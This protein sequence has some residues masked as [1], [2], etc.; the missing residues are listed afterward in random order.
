MFSLHY[1]RRLAELGVP[2]RKLLACATGSPACG[3][4]VSRMLLVKEKIFTNEKL[5]ISARKIRSTT[6]IRPSRL[7]KK[8]FRFHASTLSKIKFPKTLVADRTSK[9]KFKLKFR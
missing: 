2:Y 9:S 5:H 3:P 4:V 6:K 8:G 1:H 7:I